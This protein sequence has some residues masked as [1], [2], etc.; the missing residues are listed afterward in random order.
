MVD[1]SG[2]WGKES[3]PLMPALLLDTP[4]PASR[5]GI[6]FKKRKMPHFSPPFASS[7]AAHAKGPPAR[8][9]PVSIAQA[10]YTISGLSCMFMEVSGAIPRS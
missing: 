9:P 3:R 10:S 6:P 2:T 7:L 1:T 5:W 8:I 4:T